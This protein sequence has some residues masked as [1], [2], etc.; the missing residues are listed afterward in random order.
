MDQ[1]KVNEKVCKGVRPGG[2]AGVKSPPN[3]VGK[4]FTKFK[5]K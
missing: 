1:P 4:Q 3:N 5:V 2:A